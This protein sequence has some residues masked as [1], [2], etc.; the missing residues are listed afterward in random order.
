MPTKERSSRRSEKSERKSTGWGAVARRATEVKERKE[1]MENKIR[2][3]WLK[4]GE[5]ANIQFLQNEPYCFY[6]HNVKDK[7]KHFHV[8]PC[9]LNTQDSCVL[10]HDGVKQ[11]WKAAF[12]ILD[13][14]GKWDTDKK[15]F[16][17]GDPTEKLWM[18][19]TTIAQQLKQFIDRKGKD[20]TDM[21]IE[22][23]RSGS[24]KDSTYNFGVALD[25]DDRRI[26]PI[27]WDSETPEASELCQP[28]TDDEID[29]RGYDSGEY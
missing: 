5:S 16:V 26:K 18:V 6:A 17:G 7:D 29:E 8:V 22:V 13:F 20:L 3:F 23:T 25:D 2:D 28:P 9:Q 15:K 21:V 4:E 11:T 12:K 27:S 10:C 19:G 14:R 24:G 1:E